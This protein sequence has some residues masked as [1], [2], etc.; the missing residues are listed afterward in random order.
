MFSFSPLP[1]SLYP[2]PSLKS[3][4]HKHL[5]QV[6]GILFLSMVLEESNLHWKWQGHHKCPPKAKHGQQ[7]ETPW[8]TRR[9]RI[10]QK[11]EYTIN[12]RQ[13]RGGTANSDHKGTSYLTQEI[14]FIEQMA[15]S[16]HTSLCQTSEAPPDNFQTASTSG[17]IDKVLLLWNTRGWLG[18]SQVL[19]KRASV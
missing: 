4:I 3:R 14:S 9:S 18:P 7:C 13:G 5:I 6:L 11:T 15:M 1:S 17:N 8:L 2:L 12:P 19:E 16:L 10:S